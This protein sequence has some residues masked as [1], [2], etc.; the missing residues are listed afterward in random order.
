MIV[1]EVTY[2]QSC[3]HEAH[4][5]HNS[6]KGHQRA[7]NVDDRTSEANITAR[8]S[9]QPNPATDSNAISEY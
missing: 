5:G 3:D 8:S 1:L 9:S 4:A 7:V 2:Y 6:S